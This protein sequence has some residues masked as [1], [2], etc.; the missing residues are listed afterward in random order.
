VAAAGVLFCLVPPFGIVPLQTARQ[1]QAEGAFDAEA[2]VERFWAER[3]LEADGQALDAARLV[4]ALRQDPAA[5]RQLGRR[6][7]LSR[8]TCYWLSGVGRIRR[9][10]PEAVFIALDT[11]PEGAGVVIETGPVFGNTVRDGCGLLDVSAFANSQDFNAVSA[12]LNRRVEAQVLPGLRNRAAAGMRVK[13]P[14]CAELE[15]AATWTPLLRVVPVRIEW[16]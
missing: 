5:A 11:H 8:V 12:A 7:G 6:L 10:T 2:F 1:Q 4:A 13:F 15:D 3:L 14:G 9:V 16:P